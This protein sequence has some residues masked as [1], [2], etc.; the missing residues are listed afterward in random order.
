MLDQRQS[1]LNGRLLNS[2]CRKVGDPLFGK[3][4][5]TELGLAPGVARRGLVGRGYHGLCNVVKGKH[6]RCHYVI[7]GMAFGTFWTG[8]DNEPQ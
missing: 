5:S 4:C 7:E 8:S 6:T 3:L 2:G 1:E